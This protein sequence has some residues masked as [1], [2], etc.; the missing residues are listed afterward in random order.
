MSN[1]KL[2][3]LE[4]LIQRL[5]VVL[6]SRSLPAPRRLESAQDVL[7]LLQEQVAA[8]R[9]E[10]T[11]SA[12]ERARA[13]GYLVGLAFKALELGTLTDR[14]EKMEAAVARTEGQQGAT[15]QRSPSRAAR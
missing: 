5:T 7:A 2:R 6:R 13:I 4:S 8:I 10:A 9:A 11:T 3:R 15:T 14:L 12:V 1:T